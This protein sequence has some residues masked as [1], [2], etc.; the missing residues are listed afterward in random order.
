MF[1]T[2]LRR[3]PQ[4]GTMR[5]AFKVAD[6]FNAQIQGRTK[7]NKNILLGQWSLLSHFY[8]VARLSIWKKDMTKQKNDRPGDDGTL[9]S[10]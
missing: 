4:L 5:I 6:S 8:G 1:S 10:V 2:D 3:S 7:S 9:R